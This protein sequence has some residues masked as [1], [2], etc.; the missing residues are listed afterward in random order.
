MYRGSFCLRRIGRNNLLYLDFNSA[1]EIT[2]IMH[3]FYPADI[4]EGAHRQHAFR[5][6]PRYRNSNCLRVVIAVSFPA[7]CLILAAA[8]DGKTGAVSH[9]GKDQLPNLYSFKVGL[10]FQVLAVPYAYIDPYSARGPRVFFKSLDDWSLKVR[11][12][13]HLLI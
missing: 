13:R 1:Q 6:R 3:T 12:S 11:S 8:A 9:T 4:R 5:I 10:T 2:Q 7:S